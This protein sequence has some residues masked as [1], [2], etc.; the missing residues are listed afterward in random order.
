MSDLIALQDL[1]FTIDR[2]DVQIKTIILKRE[3]KSSIQE[4]NLEDYTWDEEINDWL[5]WSYWKDDATDYWERLIDTPC[6]LTLKEMAAITEFVKNFKWE[7]A[8]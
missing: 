3:C 7:D 8:V 6:P 4:V 1:G 2:I 5:V